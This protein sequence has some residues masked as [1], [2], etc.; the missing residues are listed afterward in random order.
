[1]E[2][3]EISSTYFS[4]YNLLNLN[5]K[6]IIVVSSILAALIAVLNLCCGAVTEAKFKKAHI[7]TIDEL[8]RINNDKD[9]ASLASSRGVSKKAMNTFILDDNYNNNQGLAPSLR[10]GRPHGGN[11]FTSNKSFRQFEVKHENGELSEVSYAGKKPVTARLNGQNRPVHFDQGFFRKPPAREFL[12][13]RNGKI[14]ETRY[15]LG[16]RTTSSF[17]RRASFSVGSTQPNFGNTR[18]RNSI[19]RK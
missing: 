17:G 7:I 6:L 8:R 13:E 3:K 10:N 4:Q 12:A 11:T 1:V 9:W 5:M 16:D 15:T 2:A 19:G 14:G 18:R